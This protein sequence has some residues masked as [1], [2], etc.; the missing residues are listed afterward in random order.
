M[1]HGPGRE[2]VP[3]HFLMM[4]PQSFLGAKK[5]G[6]DPPIWETLAGTGLFVGTLLHCRAAK[7]AASSDRQAVVNS[8]AIRVCAAI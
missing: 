8:L 6:E 7:R 3:G 2:I 4:Q 1:Q 5:A